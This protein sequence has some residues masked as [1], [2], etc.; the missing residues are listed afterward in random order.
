MVLIVSRTWGCTGGI[1]QMRETAVIKSGLHSNK[2]C[3][4]LQ[5]AS[6]LLAGL[7]DGWAVC[8]LSS[9]Q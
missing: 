1:H 4:A 2:A 5:L 7:G 6:C 9:Q 3:R 8:V